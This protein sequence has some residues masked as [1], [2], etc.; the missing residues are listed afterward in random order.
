MNSKL[1]QAF[2][3]LWLILK[4]FSQKYKLMYDLT[5]QRII[6]KL[7]NEAEIKISNSSIIYTQEHFT[8]TSPE[9]AWT[10]YKK[11]FRPANLLQPET[12][13]RIMALEIFL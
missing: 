1:R 13:A 11:V 4:H 2:A 3:K 9:E 10:F 6:Y 5:L 7:L 8:I 12:K